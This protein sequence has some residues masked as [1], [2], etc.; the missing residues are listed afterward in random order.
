MNL[1]RGRSIRRWLILF[2]LS[3]N[4]I[5]I[6]LFN[7]TVHYAL[8]LHNHRIIESASNLVH[9]GLDW[10]LTPLLAMDKTEA[11]TRLLENIGADRSIIVAMVVGAN[12]GIIAK[13]GLEVIKTAIPKLPLN[14]LFDGRAPMVSAWDENAFFSATPIKGQDSSLEHNSAV[15]AVFI[16]G[17]RMD[18]YFDSYRSFITLLNLIA[19][20][21]LTIFA[22]VLIYFMKRWFFQPLRTFGTT[23]ALVRDGNHSA[24]LGPE[25]ESQTKNYSEAQENLQKTRDMLVRQEKMAML[26]RLAAGVAHEINNPIGYIQANLSTMAKYLT[27]LIAVIDAGNKL[28][29]AAAGGGAGIAEA[30]R[31]FEETKRGQDLDF[32]ME[33]IVPLI[34][35]SRKGALR[36]GEIVQGLRAFAHDD[37]GV[38]KPCDINLILGASCTVV[39]YQ[40]KYHCVVEK[41]FGP[42]P[43]ISGSSSRLE[44]VFINLLTNAGDAIN[45]QGTIRLRSFTDGGYL[46]VTVSDDGMGMSP[47]T[48]SHIFEPFFTTKEIGKGNGLG[49]SISLGIIN[50][51]GG[52]IEVESEI[53]LGS[54]FTVVLPIENPT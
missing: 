32:L 9:S 2:I 47:E 37:E 3:G 49:L 41:D 25:V 4:L 54:T 26:G 10:A 51:H 33:D 52:R 13:S 20:A 28:A 22:A 27:S 38:R 7:L 45:G 11:I 36:I 5:L 39:E 46:M 21:S 53:G 31:A 6:L 50:E 16:L 34:D 23:A 40:L 29:E 48:A 19:I 30:S 8:N 15:A 42:L 18:A 12:G 24:H 14:E 17:L 1:G 43:M 35:D 44:Q